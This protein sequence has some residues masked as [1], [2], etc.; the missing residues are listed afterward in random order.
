MKMTVFHYMKKKYMKQLKKLTTLNFLLIILLLFSVFTIFIS[1]E[2]IRNNILNN[3]RLQGYSL[4]DT[5]KTVSLLRY[6]KDKKMDN[7]KG[8]SYEYEIT[9]IVFKCGTVNKD[10]MNCLTLNPTTRD[11]INYH[12]RS[13][14]TKS[15][16]LIL[17]K[18]TR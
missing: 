14:E 8:L 12:K 6:R 18:G 13:K 5:L 4:T 17:F 2:N 3:E 15:F 9:N 1:T 10:F 16:Y 11:A 7:V